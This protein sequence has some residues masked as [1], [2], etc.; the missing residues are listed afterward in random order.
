MVGVSADEA[1]V[2]ANQ[3]PYAA[4]GGLRRD[5]STI[6]HVHAAV[7]PKHRRTRFDLRASAPTTETAED[8][9]REY[10]EDRNFHR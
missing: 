2:R 9:C 10:E 8:W 6:I 5:H 4:P 3:P 7:P 1:P